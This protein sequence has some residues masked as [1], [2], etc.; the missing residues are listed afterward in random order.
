MIRYRFCIGIT[1]LF[2]FLN[3]HEFAAYSQESIPER[4]VA[5]DKIVFNFLNT[6]A[7][8][9]LLLKNA[10][11]QTIIAPLENNVKIFEVPEF[12][13]KK[14][15]LLEWKLITANKNR[16]GQIQIM[17]QNEPATIENY[18]GPTS[19]QAGEGDYSMLVTIPTDKLDNP[20]EDSTKVEIS[21][22]FQGQLEKDS[23]PMQ[24]MF[25]WR[26]IYTRKK[27]A[28]ITISASSKALQAKEM[29]SQVYPSTATQFS[30]TTKREHNYADGNQVVD[31]KTSPIQDAY[32]NVVSDG[33]SVEFVMEDDNGMKL[34][35]SATTISGVATAKM[36]H[37]EQPQ[38][39]Q[40]SAN[41]TGM[42]KSPSISIAFESVVK[43]FDIVPDKGENRIIAGPLESF[44][45]QFV[46][47]GA[48][49]RLRVLDSDLK[50]IESFMEPSAGGFAV[51]KLPKDK[52]YW[53]SYTFSIE[54]MGL[55]KAIYAG[56]NQ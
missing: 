37:P 6:N 55:T 46:P 20:L 45:G 35:S 23:I 53:K 3:I 27:A 44:L 19:I 54:A 47:D 18:L 8:S 14:T 31:I 12:I 48:S 2:S 16:S 39:W 21:E 4:S 5:G 29:I 10:Y 56:E 42:A 17:A 40:I 25:A 51:F 22:Y 13:E 7:S 9:R 50:V 32:G 11:A 52:N 28:N 33:T 36:L 24:N 15:G 1:L 38:T 26:N 34:K 41:V 49:V 43:D 30:I